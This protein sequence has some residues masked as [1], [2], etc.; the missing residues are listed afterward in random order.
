MNVNIDGKA[1]EEAVA[2][3]ILESA[4]GE[5]VREVV[6]ESIE[7]LTNRWG[8]GSLR[9]AL[10]RVVAEEVLKSVRDLHGEMI[11][12]AVKERITETVVKEVVGA[13]FDGLMKKLGQE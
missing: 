11:R 6:K 9:G 1:V 12:A 3:A 8:T 10:E 13:A 7:Q 5:R 4:L 2:R